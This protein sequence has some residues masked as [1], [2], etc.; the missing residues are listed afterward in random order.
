M[1]GI[2]FTWISYI[3]SD[4][5]YTLEEIKVHFSLQIFLF[6]SLLHFSWEN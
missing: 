6:S 4:F 5:F 1:F 2:N 3:I